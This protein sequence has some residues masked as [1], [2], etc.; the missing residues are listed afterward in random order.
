MF[1][2]NEIFASPH[3]KKT[4]IVQPKE[5]GI[6]ELS[7]KSSGRN[8]IKPESSPQYLENL[9]ISN[10]VFNFEQNFLIAT[11]EKVDTDK[12]MQLADN[13]A[14]FYQQRLLSPVEN[15]TLNNVEGILQIDNAA[16]PDRFVLTIVPNLNAQSRNL[17]EN[18]KPFILKIAFKKE[19]LIQFI[20]FAK[21]THI[22]GKKQ[23]KPLV[24]NPLGFSYVMELDDEQVWNHLVLLNA[25]L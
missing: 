22:V 10:F 14:V 8:I 2:I 16:S 17:P 11:L 21:K 3:F 5:H 19:D 24:L 4:A 25:L 23:P 13:E 20:Q 12:L 9:D 15:P 1:H 6:L 18:I 7:V